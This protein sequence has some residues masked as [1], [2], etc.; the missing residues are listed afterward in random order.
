[1]FKRTTLFILLFSVSTTFAGD[2]GISDKKRRMEG[3]SLGQAQERGGLSQ[4][5]V[6]E[7]GKRRCR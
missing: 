5:A 4:A 1:M 3:G 7:R 2:L 6:V